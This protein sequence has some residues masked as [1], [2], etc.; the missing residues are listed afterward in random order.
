MFAARGYAEECDAAVIEAL[1]EI[2]SVVD[3]ES[4][5]EFLSLLLDSSNA[6]D[7]YDDLLKPLLTVLIKGINEIDARYKKVIN[8]IMTSTSWKLTKP[9]RQLGSLF[10]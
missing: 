6:R 4:I 1:L 7:E 8:E 5:E 9:I 10:K 2:A 3:S